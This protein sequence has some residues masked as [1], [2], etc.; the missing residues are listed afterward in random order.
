MLRYKFLI[1]RGEGNTTLTLGGNKQ[2]KG[3]CF[4]LFYEHFL[5]GLYM[6]KGW[7]YG[8]KGLEFAR[9]KQ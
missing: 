5:F 1:E 4:L 6:T 2:N 9:V 3:F 7:G 8:K